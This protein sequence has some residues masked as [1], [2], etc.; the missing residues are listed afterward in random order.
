MQYDWLKEISRTD[1]MHLQPNYLINN[2]ISWEQAVI[3]LI[4][5]LR[6]EEE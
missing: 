4:D 3:C 1:T 5:W 2:I 6:T